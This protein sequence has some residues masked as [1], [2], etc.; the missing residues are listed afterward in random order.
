MDEALSK[1]RVMFEAAQ[2]LGWSN[3]TEVA[4]F[5]KRLEKGLPAEDELSVVFHWLGQCRLVH[6]L[7][8]FPYPP[9]V[10][11]RYRV[12]DLLAVFEIGGRP[13]PFLIEVKTSSD[14][15]L[16]WKPGF[17]SSLRNYADLLGLPLLG[18]GNT[19]PSGRSLRSSTSDRRQRTRGFPSK[20]Q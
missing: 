12:P 7:D 2:Q 3:P 6:K 19:T 5:A 10:W 17:L 20:R 15:R 16:S 4:E 9:R 18:P 11:E 8:Q 13:H 1:A 14:D